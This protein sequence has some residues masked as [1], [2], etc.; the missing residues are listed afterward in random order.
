MRR[1][2]KNKNKKKKNAATA[3]TKKKRKKKEEEEETEEKKEREIGVRPAEEVKTRSRS[4]QSIL[5]LITQVLCIT[6]DRGSL[7]FSF[8]AE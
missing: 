8:S 5:E 3:T 4:P 1:R 7:R 6:G 2:T